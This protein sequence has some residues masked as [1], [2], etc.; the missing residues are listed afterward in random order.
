MQSND[1]LPVRIIL[2]ESSSPRGAGRVDTLL[3]LRTVQDTESLDAVRCTYT[4]LPTVGNHLVH[5]AHEREYEGE[6]LH[7]DTIRI[8]TG[9]YHLADCPSLPVASTSILCLHTDNGKIYHL[10]VRTAS[11]PADGESCLVIF[12]GRL[13]RPSQ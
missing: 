12:G 9:I 11:I 5:L 10:R 8:T 4:T 13:P 1:A 3:V 2:Y 7:A 6:L